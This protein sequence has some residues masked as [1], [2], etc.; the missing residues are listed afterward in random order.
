MGGSLK[1]QT[2]KNLSAVEETWVRSLGREDPLEKE[3]STYSSL[4]AWEIPRTEEPGGLQSMGSHRVKH[5]WGTNTFTNTFIHKIGKQQGPTINYKG[6]YSISCSNL[7]R[8]RL[9]ERK[10]TDILLNHF[11][12]YLKLIHCKSTTLQ[13]KNCLFKYVYCLYMCECVSL[14]IFL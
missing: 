13:L 1:P 4:L 14:S 6:L 12:L 8:K 3:M 2:V 11:A 9:W 10:D 5:Y 7:R